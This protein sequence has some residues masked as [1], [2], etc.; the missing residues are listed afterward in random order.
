MSRTSAAYISHAIFLVGF[1]KLTL[2]RHPGL[3]VSLAKGF[4]EAILLIVT[5]DAV[6]ERLQPFP[7]HALMLAC[8]L[9]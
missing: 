9:R 4:P 8:L 1:E 7:S 6:S 5:S 2:Q 3:H